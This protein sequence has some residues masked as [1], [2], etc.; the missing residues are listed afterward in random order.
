MGGGNKIVSRKRERR[1]LTFIR[2][3]S[4]Q[5]IVQRGPPSI[6]A[7]N[8]PRKKTVGVLNSDG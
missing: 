2:K 7:V 4:L 5:K 1:R 3:Q 8:T 6:H